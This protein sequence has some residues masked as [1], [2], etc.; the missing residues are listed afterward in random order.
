MSAG[1]LNGGHWVLVTLV[2]PCQATHGA[3]CLRPKLQYLLGLESDKSRDL[4]Y[5]HY[6]AWHTAG[7][8]Y[9]GE[10][11]GWSTGPFTNSWSRGA[12]AVDSEIPGSEQGLVISQERL[13]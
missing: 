6:S 7:T 3:G 5:S 13:A 10:W 8:Q 4:F 9:L 2:S 1:S 11:V 12:E